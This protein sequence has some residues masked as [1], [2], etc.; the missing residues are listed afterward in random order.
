MVLCLP[1]FLSAMF[2]LLFASAPLLG[3]G[4]RGSITSREGGWFL[5][6]CFFECYVFLLFLPAYPYSVSDYVGLSPR[7]R[8]GGSYVPAIPTAAAADQ[9]HRP[10]C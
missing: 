5:R 8:E 2:F 4:L 1:A 7:G 10:H 3:V 9:N 6:A